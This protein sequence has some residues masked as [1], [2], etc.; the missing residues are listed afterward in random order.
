MGL[1]TE[2]YL[3]E[4]LITTFFHKLIYE[5]INNLLFNNNIPHLLIYGKPFCGKNTLIRSILYKLY[6]ESS[7]NIIN[8][9]LDIKISNTSNMHVISYKKNKNRIKY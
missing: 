2:K 3:P 4:S 5:K 6:G 7:R 9:T 8:T 1:F